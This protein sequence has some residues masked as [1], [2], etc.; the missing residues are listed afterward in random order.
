[1]PIVNSTIK[2]IYKFVRRVDL[3]FNVLIT[4]KK[5][6]K[7]YRKLEDDG[8]VCYLDCGAMSQLY[9]NVQMHQVGYIKYAPFFVNQL[10]T[11]VKL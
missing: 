3:T 7:G 4:Y 5:K 11:S 8:C 1:M 9:A 2:C 10:Y 6:P